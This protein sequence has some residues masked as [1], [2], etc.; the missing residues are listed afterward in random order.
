MDAGRGVEERMLAT[1]VVIGRGVHEG[2]RHYWDLGGKVRR[3][4]KVHFIFGTSGQPTFEEESIR[5]KVRHF[6]SSFR[7]CF[8]NH[9]LQDQELLLRTL[10]S[11][12]LYSFREIEGLNT[13]SPKHLG[14]RCLAQG[15]FS[16]QMLA[17]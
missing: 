3:K 9:W 5:R 14:T 10:R 17:C 8:S 16:I 11:C 15:H 7:F 12:P 13:L 6:T 1:V 4:V 2:S